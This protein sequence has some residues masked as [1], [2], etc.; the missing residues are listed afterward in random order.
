MPI[1]VLDPQVRSR[2]YSN[3]LGGKVKRSHAG[4]ENANAKGLLPW[5]PN[6]P[7]AVSRWLV[8]RSPGP[9]HKAASL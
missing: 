1:A 9:C 8:G 3:K 5:L 4:G 6:Y 7:D 2:D